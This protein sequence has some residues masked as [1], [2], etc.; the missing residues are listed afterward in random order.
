VYI[1][2]KSVFEPVSDRKL[3][4]YILVSAVSKMS[5]ATNASTTPSWPNRWSIH[6]S[7]PGGVSHHLPEPQ[8][9]LHRLTADET[10]GIETYNDARDDMQQVVD[11]RATTVGTRL[12]WADCRPEYSRRLCP[13]C[14]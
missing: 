12:Y 1:V 3:A 14:M 9:V 13:T 2:D 10:D 7:R 6:P 5:I 4:F 11:R 8:P